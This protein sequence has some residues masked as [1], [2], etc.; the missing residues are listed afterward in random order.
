MVS[1]VTF[2]RLLSSGIN[3]HQCVRDMIFD[4]FIKVTENEQA[5]D[6]LTKAYILSLY[7]NFINRK[8]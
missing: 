8:T 7:R 4:H 6:A 5:A 1:N 2:E 3:G